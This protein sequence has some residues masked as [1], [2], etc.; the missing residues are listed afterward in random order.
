MT[1]PSG[2]QKDQEQNTREMKNDRNK[3]QK[4]KTNSPGRE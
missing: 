3:T 4:Q 1:F 2:F